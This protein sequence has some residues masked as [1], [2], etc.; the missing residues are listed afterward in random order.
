[1]R[2]TGGDFEVST[3]GEPAER[4]ILRPVL[5]YGRAGTRPLVRSWSVW[6]YVLADRPEIEAIPAARAG[7]TERPERFVIRFGRG[8]TARRIEVVAVPAPAVSR[9]RAA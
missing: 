5:L 8:A 9:R 1:M 3:A 4:Y 2:E 7:H 6:A